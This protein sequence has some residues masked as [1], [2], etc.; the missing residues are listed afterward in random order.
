CDDGL[1]DAVFGIEHSLRMLMYFFVHVIW[2]RLGGVSWFL[3][4]SGFLS[5][6]SSVETPALVGWLFC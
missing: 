2:P 4:W 5:W 3:D 6:S 1:S